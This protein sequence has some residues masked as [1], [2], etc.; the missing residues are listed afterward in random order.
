MEVSSHSILPRALVPSAAPFPGAPGY[1]RLP[2]LFFSSKP[3]SRR[4]R[5]PSLFTPP[6]SL[7]PA[8]AA[9]HFE[10]LVEKDWSFLD[11]G[12][13]DSD[14]ARKVDRV[15]ASADV[16]VGSRVLACLPTPA[17]VDRLMETA[18]CELVLAVHESLL[19]LADIKERHDAVRCWQGGVEAVP[20]RF[21]PLDVVFICYFPAIGVALDQ[22]LGSLARRCSR[23][24]RV[25]I[26][27]EQGRE[28][29]EG[30]HRQQHPETVISNLPDKKSLEKAAT[31]HSF[32]ITEFVDDSTFYLAVLRPCQGP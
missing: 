9:V 7:L 22:L 5:S 27:C 6:R 17:F 23:G 30:I 14:R 4:R 16:D 28:T 21:C 20:E 10:D 1:S 11:P 19:V 15:I 24:A 29:V 25:L 8:I 12:P 2:C 18:P 26:T 31:E 32:Q 3:H 13:A